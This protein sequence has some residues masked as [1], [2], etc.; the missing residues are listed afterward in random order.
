MFLDQLLQPVDIN[1]VGIN[2]RTYQLRTIQTK[3]LDGC[4]KSGRLD[5]HFVSRR[6]HGFSNQVQRLLAAGCHDQALWCNRGAFGRHE[7]PDLLAQRLPPFR[8]TVLQNRARVVRHNK[9]CCNPKTFDIKQSR[10]WKATRKTDDSGFTQQLEQLADGRGFNLIQAIGKL[11]R[12]GVSF[13]VVF[14]R[15][16]APVFLHL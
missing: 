5:N 12:H 2:R 3:T 9:V 4:Q 8:R 7:N 13:A 1:A 10:V 11:Q 16:V 15:I 14:I 6:D